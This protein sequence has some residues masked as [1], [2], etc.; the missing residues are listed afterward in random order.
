MAAPATSTLPVFCRATSIRTCCRLRHADRQQ[1]HLDLDQRGPGGPSNRSSQCSWFGPLRRAWDTWPR[2]SAGWRA[3]SGWQRL[4]LMCFM[5][6]LWQHDAA[7][8]RSLP[9]TGK[10]T[11]AYILAARTAQP[12]PIPL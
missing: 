6:C 11:L 2:R 9:L 7:L 1:H 5:T 12:C 4:S 8:T 3:L 10:R